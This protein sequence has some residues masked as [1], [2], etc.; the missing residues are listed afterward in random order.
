MAKARSH[1]GSAGV[2]H[3][4]AAR[5]GSTFPLNNEFT[6]AGHIA[7]LRS[8]SALLLMDCSVDG[9]VSRWRVRRGGGAE[10]IS[11]NFKRS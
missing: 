2:Q 1:L 4:C 6:R 11:I 9:S 8:I 5:F 3:A 10:I 7:R